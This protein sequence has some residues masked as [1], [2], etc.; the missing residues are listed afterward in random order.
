MIKMMF[1]ASPPTIKI[2]FLSRSATREFIEKD[3]DGY[4]AGL[5]PRDISARKS[6][7]IA[8]Y[9]GVAARCCSEFSPAQKK[10]LTDA[11]E[12]A[13]SLMSSVRWYSFGKVVEETLDLNAIAGMPWRFACVSAGDDYEAGWPH[14]R[15]DVIFLCKDFF[16][17]YYPS[18]GRSKAYDHMV[19]TLVHEK[20]HVFQRSHA[21]FM[22]LWNST[23]GY[24][25]IA[26]R[27]S[28][29]AEA[30]IRSNPD[31]DSYVYS[32]S[33]TPCF[34]RYRSSRPKDMYDTEKVGPTEHPNEDMAYKIAAYVM[35]LRPIAPPRAPPLDPA[36]DAYCS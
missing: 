19:E 4:L 23:Q 16:K 25:R 11:A 3:A 13:D 7:T 9:A 31:L 20:V 33:R 24:Q 18:S 30:G 26:P 36:S 12:L 28:F 21:E 14:T 34:V 1:S 35:G 27:S 29:P 2:E 17:G 10:V 22:R 32:I 15:A 6:S 5:T 8:E